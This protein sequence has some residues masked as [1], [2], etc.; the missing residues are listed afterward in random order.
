MLDIP[1]AARTSSQT[2]EI[3]IDA[4]VPTPNPMASAALVYGYEAGASISELAAQFGIHRTTVTQHLHRNHVTMRRRGLG[5]RQID[6]A[7]GMYQR[8]NSLARIGAHLD[9]HAETVRQALRARGVE[10]REPWG[11]G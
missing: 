9:V 3:K 4:T 10:L 7:V 1:G 11:R 2:A 5:N 8:G 6:Q